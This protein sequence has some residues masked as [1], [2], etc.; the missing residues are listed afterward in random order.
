MARYWL[1]VGSAPHCSVLL[2]MAP[3]ERSRRN[4]RT[5]IGS[6]RSAACL[7]MRAFNTW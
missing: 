2:A 1:F 7:S 5:N 4:R 6:A 3:P